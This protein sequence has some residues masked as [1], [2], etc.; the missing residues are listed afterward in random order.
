[1]LQITN[2]KKY[3]EAKPDNYQEVEICACENYVQK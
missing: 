1:M 3:F 2:M